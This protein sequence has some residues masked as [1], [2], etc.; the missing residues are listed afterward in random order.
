MKRK[1]PED[2]AIIHKRKFALLPTATNDGYYIWFEWYTQE[3]V[4]CYYDNYWRR[5][6]AYLYKEETE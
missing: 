1:L 6:R 2:G 3:Y 5:Q 4:Y